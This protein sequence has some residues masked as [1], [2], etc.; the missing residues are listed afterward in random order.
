[1]VVAA[2]QLLNQKVV[3]EL[4]VDGSETDCRVY[5]VMHCATA[6]QLGKLSGKAPPQVVNEPFKHLAKMAV[7]ELQ[8]VDVHQQPEVLV[9]VHHFL[10]LPAEAHERLGVE[11]LFNFVKDQTQTA[12]DG[13]LIPGY[14][15]TKDI[16]FGPVVVIDIAERSPCPGGNVTHRGSVKALFDKE[17]PGRFLDTGFVLLDRAGTEFWHSAYK[18]ERPY[19]IYK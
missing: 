16:F 15:R 19:F 17:F 9:I 2:K 12:V 10:D 13:R 18:N 14:N 7:L 1:M 4:H 8:H 11:R 6:L 5:V 3:E